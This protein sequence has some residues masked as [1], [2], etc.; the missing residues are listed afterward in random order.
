MEG[1]VTLTQKE[2]KRLMVISEVER[3]EVRGREA[4]AVLG[5]SLR[6]FRRMIAAYRG[7]GARALA[8]G[9]RGRKPVNAIGDEVRRCVVDLAS[10]RYSGFNHQ[11]FTEFLG[12]KKVSIFRVPRCVVSCSGRG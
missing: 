10:T 11:H 3:E 6:H 12:G 8:H 1:K 7:E 4:A 5:I 2:Q 9:N